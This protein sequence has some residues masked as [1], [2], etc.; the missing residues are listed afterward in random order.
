M[1][2]QIAHKV[3]NAAGYSLLSLERLKKLRILE[4]YKPSEN[5]LAEHLRR[6]FT[7]H[8]VDCVFDVGANDGAYA[9]WL[10]SE[11]GFKGQVVSFEPIADQ[12]RILEQKSATDPLWTIFSCALGRVVGTQEFHVMESDVF[13]SFLKPDPS[14]PGKYADSNRVSRSIPVE[15]STVAEVWQK[16][17]TQHGLSHLYLKMDTQGFDLEVFA[18]AHDVLDSIVALQSELAFRGIY[19]DGADY[20]QAM[21]VFAAAG[22]RPSM[23]HPISFD[24]NL[25]MIEADGVFVR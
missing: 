19:Q 25:A 18:G 8:Q 10:R 7:R 16:I 21:S 12:V 24:E 5:V 22:F 6:V 9:E 23:L 1:I 3:L 15:V 17:R 20:S 14:Q 13:S 2:G 4:N 11:V